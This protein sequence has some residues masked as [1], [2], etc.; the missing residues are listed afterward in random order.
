MS[1]EKTDQQNENEEQ[2]NA[3]QQEDSL[4]NP[5]ATPASVNRVISK[6][7]NTES[8]SDEDRRAMDTEEGLRNN[9]NLQGWEPQPQQ[10][11]NPQDAAKQQEELQKQQEEEQKRQIEE[12]QKRHEESLK[13]LSPDQRKLREKQIKEANELIEQQNKTMEEKQKRQEEADKRNAEFEQ[14]ETQKFRTAQLAGRDSRLE[15]TLPGD[16]PPGNYMRPG[17]QNNP[18]NQN[19][20]V[21]TPRSAL[22][23][24]DDSDDKS[25]EKN[26]GGVKNTSVKTR[27]KRRFYEGYARPSNIAEDSRKLIEV[28]VRLAI[29]W[30][31]GQPDPIFILKKGKEKC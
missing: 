20:G 23:R 2:K 15:V 27:Q 17:D 9:V 22:A 8:I 6:G 16:N 4:N 24:N 19:L 14:E 28:G 25:G 10:L 11:Q 12:N 7:N 5:G 18:N 21:A 13:A 30:E 29:P 3:K 1:K 31:E 26:K